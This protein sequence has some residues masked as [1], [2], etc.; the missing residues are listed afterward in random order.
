MSELDDLVEL[1]QRTKYADLVKDRRQLE[2]LLLTQMKGSQ[3]PMTREIGN[4]I[5]GGTMSWRTLATNSAYS[6]FLTRAQESMATF[7]LEPALA[8]LTAEA[9]A[10][11]AAAEQERASRPEPRDK[12]VEDR[13]ADEPLFDGG[14]MKKRKP[15]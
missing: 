6:E 15:R 12:K 1:A 4:G 10:E 7:S 8:T 11:A 2:S 9:E 5:A 3:D 13:A 14:L